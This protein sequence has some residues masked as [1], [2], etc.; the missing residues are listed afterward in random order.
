MS[1]KTDNDDNNT[2]M[3][4]DEKYK[5]QLEWSK[6]YYLKNKNEICQKVNE[7][8]R[9]EIIELLNNGTRKSRESTLK[10]YNIIKQ[11]DGKYVLKE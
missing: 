11:A 10:K 2:T 6:N 7:R 1:N 8:R 9:N 5:K 4:V 3:S